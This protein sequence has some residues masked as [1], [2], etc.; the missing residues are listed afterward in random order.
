MSTIAYSQNKFAIPDSVHLYKAKPISLYLNKQ[1]K[2][3][4]KQNERTLSNY[5]VPIRNVSYNSISLTNRYNATPYYDLNP[6]RNVDPMGA[7]LEGTL[8]FLF[9]KTVYGE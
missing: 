7:V 8:N 5:L 6:T 2:E 4:C 9:N 1:P 3:F